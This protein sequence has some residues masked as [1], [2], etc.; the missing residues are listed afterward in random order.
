MK[1]HNLCILSSDSSLKRCSCTQIIRNVLPAD[2]CTSQIVT[3]AIV[4]CFDLAKTICEMRRLHIHL[5]ANNSCSG[6]IA[7]SFDKRG[8]CKRHESQ[9]KNIRKPKKKK[10]RKRTPQKSGRQ[11]K[12]IRGGNIGAIT[13]RKSLAM[14]RWV[15][16]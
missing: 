13:N 10:V 14:C 4:Y 6:N 11:I 3:T 5:N 8:L 2:F 15:G 12:W 9:K 16:V 7:D 1:T